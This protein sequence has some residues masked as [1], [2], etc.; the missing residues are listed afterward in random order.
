MVRCE[1]RVWIRGFL[2]MKKTPHQQAT[3][4]SA[5]KKKSLPK[6][7]VR[8]K[9]GK[10][11]PAPAQ[12]AYQEPAIPQVSKKVEESLNIIKEEVISPQ[13]QEVLLPKPT[14]VFD[15]IYLQ[16]IKFEIAGIRQARERVGRQLDRLEKELSEHATE[17]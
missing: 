15:K 11:H 13:P 2:L 12:K 5:G 7:K 9:H 4:K 16:S 6:P 10:A 3:K 14:V 1:W 17:E 8:A